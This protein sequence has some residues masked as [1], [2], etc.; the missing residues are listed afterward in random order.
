MKIKIPL[1]C[2]KCNSR[3]YHIKKEKTNAKRLELN[4]YC[5]YCKKT[6]IHRESR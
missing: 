3:N 6:T 2:T 5:P 4:K 1:I